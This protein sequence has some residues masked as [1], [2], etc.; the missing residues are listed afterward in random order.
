MRS[1]GLNEV[2]VV[3]LFSFSEFG[4]LCSYFTPCGVT[5]VTCS[6]VHGVAAKTFCIYDDSS[7]G[8]VRESC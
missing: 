3:C 1:S 2:D 8:S 5:H 7:P 6:A 4:L